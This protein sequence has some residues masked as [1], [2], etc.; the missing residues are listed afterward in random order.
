M[1]AR[2]GRTALPSRLSI[3]DGSLNYEMLFYAL[4]IGFSKK[5]CIIGVT[6]ALLTL[7]TIGAVFN[8]Q[9]I[10]LRF[11]VQPISLEIIF[12]MGLAMLF[13]AGKLVLPNA[14]RVLIAVAAL[15]WLWVNPLPPLNAVTSPNSLDRV[16]GWGLPMAALFIAT[17]SRSDRRA[18]TLEA[19]CGASGRCLL[20]PLFDSPILAAFVHADVQASA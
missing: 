8:P 11:W 15:A 5:S 12:G 7:S 13:Q 3:S 1:T 14:A 10:A 9:N 20:Q 17:V 6:A 18:G 4:F 19:L 2:V 16:L